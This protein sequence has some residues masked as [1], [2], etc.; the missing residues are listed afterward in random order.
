MANLS[1]A[2]I[3]ALSRSSFG[4]TI[5]PRSSTLMIDSTLQLPI[6]L[7]IGEQT[8]TLEFLLDIE[9]PPLTSFLMKINNQNY[10]ITLMLTWWTAF[11]KEKIRNLEIP[12]LW[13]LSV[14]RGGFSL[15]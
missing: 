11:V 12:Q 5:C 13:V 8:V 4:S 9:L 15:P 1:P 2:W 7:P 3:F 14:G 6:P 10:Q